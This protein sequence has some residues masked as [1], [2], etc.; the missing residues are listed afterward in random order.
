MHVHEHVDAALVRQ[1]VVVKQCPTRAI[2][3]PTRDI[4]VQW[5]LLTISL[6]CVQQLSQLCSQALC[7]IDRNCM[8]CCDEAL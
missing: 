1:Q 2:V 5:R 8:H 7:K 4:Q 3:K 6:V